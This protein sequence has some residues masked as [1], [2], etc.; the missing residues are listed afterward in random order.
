MYF[1][2]AIEIFSSLKIEVGLGLTFQVMISSG[3]YIVMSKK[4][5][6]EH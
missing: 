5:R 2:F 3:T 1:E 6:I 4:E